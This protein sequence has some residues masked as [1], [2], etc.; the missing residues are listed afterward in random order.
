MESA[1]GCEKVPAVGGCLETSG[2]YCSFRLAAGD[3]ESLAVR[4]LP[5]AAVATASLDSGPETA[6]LAVWLA[7][8]RSR[9]CRMSDS[10]RSACSAYLGRARRFSVF[11]Y[12]GFLFA[13][14]A[15]RTGRW[16]SV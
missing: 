7:A 2:R 6:A 4:A 15:V 12:L 9:C 8:C 13:A 3:R 10:N 5:A 11:S 16:S 1:F 14:V